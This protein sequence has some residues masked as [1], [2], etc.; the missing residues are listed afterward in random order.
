MAVRIRVYVIAWSAIC[1]A[2]AYK[3]TELSN[4]WWQRYRALTILKT[5]KL[6]HIHNP[7][8]PSIHITEQRGQSVPVIISW[9]F[10][11]LS[12]WQQQY[13]HL[14]Q[15]SL[16]HNKPYSKIHLMISNNP[17]YAHVC[18]CILAHVPSHPYTLSICP[19]LQSCCSNMY[20]LI[21]LE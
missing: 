11:R 13:C 19:M 17:V 1:F 21:S 14:W 3:H 6:F 18:I 12:L 9:S 15:S 2:H 8:H 7:Y 10:N 5:N 4:H 20:S 16:N